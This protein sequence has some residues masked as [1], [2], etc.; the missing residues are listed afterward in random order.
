MRRIAI[1]R[2]LRL[3]LL[4]AACG[5]AHGITLGRLF[6]SP[7]DRAQ[8]DALRAAGT[9][10][11]QIAPPPAA[12]ATAAPPAPAPPPPEPVVL[13]GIIKRSDGK[14]TI[15]LNQTPQD[16]NPNLRAT[17]GALSLRLPSGRQVI[18]Q[19]GQR[20]DPLDGKVKDA[21]EP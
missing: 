14:S 1:L 19:P 21:H 8:I 16:D 3:L 6:T 4:L 2:A 17:K 7:A 10:V 18:L 13:N 11:Q 12:D 15:W 9:N 20:Y 5:A